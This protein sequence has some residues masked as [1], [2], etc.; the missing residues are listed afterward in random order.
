[1]AGG[2]FYD[3]RSGDVALE[4]G[5]SGIIDNF[6]KH[7]GVGW[8]GPFSNLQALVN[9]YNANAANNPGWVPPQLLPYLASNPG[10]TGV[11]PAMR[12]DAGALQKLKNQLQGTA[13][14]AAQNAGSGILHGFHL[15][16]SGA[17]HFFLRLAEGIVGVAFLIIGLNALLKNPAGK[18]ASVA[19][20]VGRAV[21]AVKV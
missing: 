19:T 13:A 1:M 7:L 9:F 14:A 12:Q 21:K 18:V 11:T 8:H 5:I 20:P 10:L 15:A 16:W 17:G 6:V 4:Q 3:S 2:W